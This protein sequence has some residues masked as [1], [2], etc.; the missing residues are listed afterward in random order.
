MSK[1]ELRTRLR[2]SAKQLEE[3]NSF[4]LA[5]QNRVIDDFL[6]VVSKYGTPEE[7]NEKA[8]KAG[9][10][11]SLITRLEKE[12]SPY[13]PDV[14]WL[15]AQREARAFVSVAEYRRSVLGEKAEKTKFR[16]DFAVILEISAAQYF[17]WVIEEAKQA[18]ARR[19]LMPGR[20]IR[21]R[22]M[23]EQEKDQGDILAFAAA[24]QI[25]GATFVETL[26]TKGTDGSNVHLG[27]P[28]TITGYFGGIGQPNDYPLR[29]VDEFLYYYTNYGIRQVLNINP[30]TVF[31]G[32]LLRKLG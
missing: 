32:Y 23:K 10:L 15:A 21:V 20:F 2:I 18:I 24:M 28:E 30:G 26:D 22:K 5:P 11:E 12:K 17:P 6:D 14:K 3:I 1:E 4:L 13:L 16:D 19:E 8:Q 7:I 29:W 9:R 31:A 25:M 27:G